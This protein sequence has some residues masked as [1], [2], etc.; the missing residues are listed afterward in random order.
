MEIG[1]ISMLSWAKFFKLVTLYTMSSL[2]CI[3]NFPLALP[4]CIYPSE[5]PNYSSQ[6]ASLS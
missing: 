1:W 3:I 4:I 6:D 5:T 2:P